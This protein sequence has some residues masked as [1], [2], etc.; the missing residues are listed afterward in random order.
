MEIS[1]KTGHIQRARRVEDKKGWERDLVK[2]R[3]KYNYLVA[4]RYMEIICAFDPP[5][6]YDDRSWLAA[7]LIPE[8]YEEQS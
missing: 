7:I 8:D 3:R 6:S 5:L 1:R 4:E 2:L